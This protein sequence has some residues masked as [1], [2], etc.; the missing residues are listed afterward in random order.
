[1]EKEGTKAGWKSWEE[2]KAMAKDRD[3]WRKSSTAL[4]VTEREEDR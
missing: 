1:M 4:C 2:V 3:K